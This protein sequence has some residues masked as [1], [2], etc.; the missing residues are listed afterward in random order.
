MFI[1][2]SLQPTGLSI[3]YYYNKYSKGVGLQVLTTLV[4]TLP[5]WLQP[6]C[7]LLWELMVFSHI[8]NGENWK[9][10][11][12]CLLSFRHPLERCFSLGI[13]FC[14]KMFC[15]YWPYFIRNHLS[16]LFLQTKNNLPSV[17]S[18]SFGK[19]FFTWHFILYENVLF[20][21]TI[22]YQEPF[23]FSI[24]ALCFQVVTV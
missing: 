23:V 5:L 4:L 22:F 3:F 1:P 10:R 19:M 13:L 14:M 8:V 21:L 11:I 2:G 17:L 12:I 15:S 7:S 24:S 18:T 16:F 6:V 9:P 20:L